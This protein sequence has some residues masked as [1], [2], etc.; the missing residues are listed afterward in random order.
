MDGGG[1]HTTLPR[2]T[3]NISRPALAALGCYAVAVAVVPLLLF[4][5]CLVSDVLVYVFL[6]R[7]DMT[8]WLARLRL[9]GWLA[10][11]AWASLAMTAMTE[12]PVHSTT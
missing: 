4:A 12:E 2:C 11:Q 5:F 8:T 1:P 3:L 6:V 9:C 7:N 10:M